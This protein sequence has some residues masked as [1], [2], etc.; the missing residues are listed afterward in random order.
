MRLLRLALIRSALMAVGAGLLVWIFGVPLLQSALVASVA[1]TAAVGN[2]LRPF[3][4]EPGWP[5]RIGQRRHG[6]R[7]E[8]AR[9]AS[10]LSARERDVSASIV[11]RLRGLAEQRLAR[12]GIDVHDPRDLAAA[13]DALGTT[14]HARLFGDL[15]ARSRHVEFLR[16][17]DAV[18][19]LAPPPTA[20]GAS[21]PPAGSSLAPASPVSTVPPEDDARGHV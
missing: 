19:R 14:V 4:V 9:L 21:R 12:A 20:P 1:F 8:V 15:D 7:R 16:C 6:T 17:L 10:S 5:D 18:E 11:A 3:A 13:R 2:T